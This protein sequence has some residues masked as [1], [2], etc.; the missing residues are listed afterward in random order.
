MAMWGIIHH[1]TKCLLLFLRHKCLLRLA[2]C[3]HRCDGSGEPCG[4]RRFGGF[5]EVV[6][7]MMLLRPHLQGSW[8][9]STKANEDDRNSLRG[10]WC[11]EELTTMELCIE[12]VTM[13]LYKKQEGWRLQGELVGHNSLE[14]LAEPG[15]MSIAKTDITVSPSFLF[16]IF[17]LLLSFHLYV[18]C[19][20]SLTACIGRPSYADG[21]RSATQVAIWR[22]QS[23]IFVRNQH[24]GSDFYLMRVVRIT[25]T[26][27]IGLSKRK[28]SFYRAGNTGLLKRKRTLEIM[29]RK[30]DF[31]NLFI[32]VTELPWPS[33]SST[34]TYAV[35][36]KKSPKPILFE[37]LSL[38]YFALRYY[39]KELRILTYYFYIFGAVPLASFIYFPGIHEQTE[40]SFKDLR[41]ADFHFPGLL[42][43]L[44]AT[45]MPEPML[46][47]D[48]LA[49][50]DFL[51]F[52]SHLRK[53]NGTIANTFNELESVA[54]KAI[55]DDVCVPDDEPPVEEKTK[56]NED[57]TI[58]FDL[59]ELL[60]EGF[61]EITRGLGMVVKFW[62][63]QVKVLKDSVGRFVTH[64]GWNS[65]LEVVVLSVPMMAWPLYAEQHLNKNVLAK[66]MGKAIGVE[67]R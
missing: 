29:G 27:N 59:D 21:V 18:R 23:D 51:Y 45:H 54:I 60:L 35:P 66:D 13:C 33:S 53:A 62:A 64:C 63:P 39:G 61:G 67:Q 52:C 8:R 19:W 2:K 5:Q 31:N 30:E 40:K 20:H 65:V 49:Y 58:D 41:D 1:G 7:K 9:G 10:V 28:R 25:N 26:A 12:R 34:S 4:G 6:T 22:V 3:Q 36:Y 57:V 55:A 48:D 16:F 43:P 44:K 14:T 37:L 15:K 38:T 32:T 24:S 42:S 56:Q 11:V 50:W 17:S 46:D 47:R